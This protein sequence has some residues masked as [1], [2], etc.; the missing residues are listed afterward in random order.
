MSP[1]EDDSLHFTS[2]AALLTIGACTQKHN[3]AL[4]GKHAMIYAHSV[5]KFLI[6]ASLAAPP[7][8]AQTSACTAGSRLSGVVHDDT[9]AVIPGAAL[10][11]DGTAKRTSD[12][13]GRFTFG[14][15]NSG[16][17]T[18]SVSADAF[19]EDKRE[20]AVKAAGSV[21]LSIALLVKG[22]AVSIDATNEP[23]GI[24]NENTGGSKTITG[25]DLAKMADDPDDFKRQLQVLAA[26]GGGTP[27]NATISVDGFQEGAALPP[28]GSIAF[29]RVNPDLFSAE[30]GNPPYEGGRIEI[31]TKP[32]GA[33]IH[34]ALFMT[35]SPTF[36][37]ARDPFALTRA[38][39]GKQRYGF[40]FS[41]PIKPNKLDY[42]LNL[43]KRDIDNFAVVN[44]YTITSATA[45]ATNVIANVPQAQHLWIASARSGWQV[46]KKNLATFSYSANVNNLQNVD[47][48][49]TTL[50][51]AGYNSGQGEHAIRG[52]VITTVSPRMVHEGRVAFTLR[53]RVDTPNSTAP[54]ISVPGAFTSGGAS[55]GAYQSH[56][57]NLELNDDVLYNIGKHNIKAG[58]IS[59]M[60]MDR[61]V[62]PTGFNGQFYFG[63]CYLDNGNC[64]QSLPACDPSQPGGCPPPPPYISGI[65]QYRRALAKQPGGSATTYSITTG[66]RNINATTVMTSFYIQD[67]YKITSHL[68]LAAGIRYQ[69]QNNPSI[70]TSF[71]PRLGVAWSPDKKQK[72]VLR[73]RVGLFAQP[74]SSMTNIELVRLNGVRQVPQTYYG[75]TLENPTSAS[76]ISLR[77]TLAPHFHQ[78]FSVQSQV[79]AE[80]AFPHGWNVQANVFPV[81]AWNTQRSRNINAP[82]NGVPS[83]PRPFEP[84]TNVYQVQQSGHFRGLVMFYGLDQHAYKR[85]QIFLGYLHMD[86]HTNNDNPFTTP[87][88]ATSDAGES[89]RPSWQSAH[90]IFAIGTLNLPWKLALS[91]N[92]DAAS[93]NP[94]NIT[95]GIDNNGD[96]VFNDR[97]FYAAA[98]SPSAVNT[99]YGTLTG[100][101]GG[102]GPIQRNL[103]TLP[104]SIHIDSNLS[105]TFKLPGKPDA[106]RSIT[107]NIRAANLLNHRNV[108]AVGSVLGSPLFDVPYAAESGRRLEGG[109]RYSF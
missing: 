47:V 23:T 15:V 107:A 74:L 61:R 45:P 43:E 65:D 12:G 38:A 87:Q 48:G 33:Q 67:Q 39:V 17:H 42:S 106:A 102:G 77:R 97:P 82:L 62:S 71:M 20:V 81:T 96:G 58:I 76:P 10:L 9:G 51:E 89:S 30:Y 44:A 41:G 86:F 108:V 18:L 69:F 68:Q 57:K 95:I 70:Y 4:L 7:L 105:R 53:N 85:A 31:Y 46:N 19:A 55:S 64:V 54:S 80:Y 109:V 11:L 104:W 78:S 2:L 29:I 5:T 26:A 79:A 21:E 1:V 98:G 24:E 63:G 34:G 16:K 8:A 32:G 91:S 59:N 37:N 50:Q 101:S 27:G 100:A 92:S 6:A 40:E 49:G 60:Y 66:T 35:Y 36:L 99:R 75:T 3:D 94:F 103:G 83:G 84:N 93:G 28:K 52:V 25:N 56:F 22:E 73:A 14:C 90:R 72:L 88:S 13:E